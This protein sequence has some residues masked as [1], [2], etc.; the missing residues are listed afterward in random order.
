MENTSEDVGIV[1]EVD[2]IVKSEDKI[3]DSTTITAPVVSTLSNE[4]AT[5]AIVSI[6]VEEPSK[7]IDAEVSSPLSP[8]NSFISTT[9]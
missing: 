4:K 1:K 2:S 6:T 8:P 7:M 9:R 5:N 3:D